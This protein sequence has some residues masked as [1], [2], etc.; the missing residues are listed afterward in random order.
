MRLWQRAFVSELDRLLHQSCGFDVDGI[1]LLGGNFALG[2]D[3]F[4]EELEGVAAPPVIL[5]LLGAVGE[6]VV[7]DRVTVVAIG[8]AFQERRSLS[9]AGAGHGLA[10]CVEDRKNVHAVHV[11]AGHVVAGGA[12]GDA[13]GG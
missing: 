3:G 6:G 4:A 13:A 11:D 2:D 10:G 1:Q 8:A 5:L 9:G 12:V 7:E